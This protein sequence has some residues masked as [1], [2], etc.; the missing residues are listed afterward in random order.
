MI[1]W[2]FMAAIALCFIA[3][4]IVIVLLARELYRQ[5]LE[6]QILRKA[7][8]GLANQRDTYSHSDETPHSARRQ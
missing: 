6:I 3:L 7:N 4:T 8:G 2:L 1:D 5:S